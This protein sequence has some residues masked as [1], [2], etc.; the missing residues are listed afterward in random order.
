MNIAAT[1]RARGS[2]IGE[3]GVDLGMG[4]EDDPEMIG[5]MGAELEMKGV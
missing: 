2:V 3:K 1:D 5:G 4:A